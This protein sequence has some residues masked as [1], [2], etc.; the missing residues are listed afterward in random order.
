M[1]TYR[2][3]LHALSYTTMDRAAMHDTCQLYFCNA[4]YSSTKS[5]ELDIS[6]DCEMESLRQTL[7]VDA[8]ML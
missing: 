7:N 8:N 5:E 1:Q 3:R 2:C 4:S 6:D